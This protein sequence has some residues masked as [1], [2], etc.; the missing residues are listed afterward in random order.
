MFLS[1]TSLANCV[2]LFICIYSSTYCSGCR[3]SRQ[4]DREHC[5][6]ILLTDGSSIL[7]SS[8]SAETTQSWVLSICMAVSKGIQVIVGYIY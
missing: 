2:C 7:F 6:E 1:M 5:F 4:L 8:E 3:L